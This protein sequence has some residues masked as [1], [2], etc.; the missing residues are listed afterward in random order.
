MR[1]ACAI[2]GEQARG[3]EDL[4]EVLR[5][6]LSPDLPEGTQLTFV[7]VDTDDEMNP[8][9]RPDLEAEVERGRAAITA[10]R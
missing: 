2:H 10:P 9:E 8:E 3:G 5:E 1:T 6:A 4:A 7:M